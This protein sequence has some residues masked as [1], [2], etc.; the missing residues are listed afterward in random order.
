M[1]YRRQIDKPLGKILKE[2]NIISDAQLNQALQV[3]KNDGGLFGEIIVRLGFASEE[4][5]AQCISFQYGFPYLPL[6]NF[7]VSEEVTT[8]IPRHVAHHYCLMPVDKIG[9]TLTVA[10]SNPLNREAV[11][12]IEDLTSLEIQIFISTASDIRQAI[13]R[14]YKT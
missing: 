10:M 3:Q 2:R 9:N 7:E 12:D 6:E 5:I 8:I 1:K 13:G 4:D 14:H 11:E